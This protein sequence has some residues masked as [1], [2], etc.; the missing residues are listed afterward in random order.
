MISRLN[1]VTKKIA[2][3]GRFLTSS[4]LFAPRYCEIMDAKALRVCPNTQ[5]SIDIKVVT[6]PTAAKASVG[7]NSTLPRTAASVNDK[8]GS[9]IPEISAGMASL[10]ICFKL[11]L[12]L[13]E[14]IHN[15][16]KGIHFA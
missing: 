9:D 8:I 4:R 14:L 12:V 13:T 16:K 15:N 5:M 6:M 10:L 11:M 7:F 3:A 2:C 1:E